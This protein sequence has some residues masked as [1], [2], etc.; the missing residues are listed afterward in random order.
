MASGPLY[1]ESDLFRK[2]QRC[3]LLYRTVERPLRSAPEGC[4]A[5]V[6]ATVDRVI[7]EHEMGV[8]TG[9][10]CKEKGCGN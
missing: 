9:K 1:P 8:D 4:R 10:V 2:P 7:G 6:V 3:M 5:C